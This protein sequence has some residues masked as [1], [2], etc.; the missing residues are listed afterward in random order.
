[1]KNQTLYAFWDYDQC[2]YMLGGEVVKFIEGG[3][4]HAKGYGTMCFKPIAILA[5][6]DGLK[7]INT[8]RDLRVRYDKQLR[9][10]KK[11]F[12][13]AAKANVGLKEE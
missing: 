13:I 4:V 11:A 2:P 3:K 6:D 1:M 7:A 10:L 12:S 9:E 5:D 8:L